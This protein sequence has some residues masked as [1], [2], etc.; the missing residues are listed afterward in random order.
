VGTLARVNGAAT[1]TLLLF[2]TVLFLDMAFMVLPLAA[3]AIELLAIWQLY[4][5]QT[6]LFVDAPPGMSG[7]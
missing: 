1:V 6:D 2:I 7:T 4:Q 5:W 3:L